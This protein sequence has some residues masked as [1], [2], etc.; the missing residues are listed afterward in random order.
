MKKMPTEEEVRRYFN[1]IY[2]HPDDME[3]L[4]PEYEEDDDV[5]DQHETASTSD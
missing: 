3:M 5:A 2:R 1:S 4:Y